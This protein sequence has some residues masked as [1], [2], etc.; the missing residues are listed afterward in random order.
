MNISQKLYSEDLQNSLLVNGINRL[1]DSKFLITGA[2]GLIG[3]HLIDTLMSLGDVRVVALGRSRTKAIDR[4]GKH[5]ANPYF[6]FM[7]HDVR[8]SLPKIP[9]VDYIFPLASNTHPI[10]YSQFPIETMMTNIKGLENV[11]NYADANGAMVLFPSSVEVYGNARMESDIFSEEDTGLLNLLNSRACY[12]EAKRACEAMCQSYISER[13]VK[14]KIV[15]LARVFGPTMLRTDTK[16]MSQFI[17]NAVQ[18]EDIIMKSN[19]N[20]LFSYVYVS[21]AVNALFHVLLYGKIGQ[22]YNVSSYSIRLK[23]IALMCAGF[24]STTLRFDFADNIEKRGYSIAT[25][26]VLNN[27]KLLDLGWSPKY[28]INNAIERTIIQLKG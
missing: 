7:E 23:D 25:V 5:F 12:S 26:A 16:A 15:R 8:T 20:Q 3:S 19:G 6:Q 13:N 11:L 10:A 2:T 1:K 21:D 24:A 17:Y 28:S 4:L 9:D 27:S 18:D 14:I 22:P